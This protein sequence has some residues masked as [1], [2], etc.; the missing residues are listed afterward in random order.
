MITVVGEGEPQDGR[1]EA[2]RRGF[3]LREAS[4]CFVR[5]RHLVSHFAT[6]TA[7]SLAAQQT[8]G[9]ADRAQKTARRGRLFA[10]HCTL[11]YDLRL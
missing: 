9:W 3:S 6:L 5:E 4:G 8:C 2:W 7:V 10:V 1:W 11:R